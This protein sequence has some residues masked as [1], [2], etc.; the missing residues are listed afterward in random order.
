MKAPETFRPL[1]SSSS[2]CYLWSQK[3]LK[4]LMWCWQ[5]SR[6]PSRCW[7]SV[8]SRARS[9]QERT[10]RSWFGTWPTFWAS[11][12]GRTT[13]GPS[14]FGAWRDKKKKMIWHVGPA[15]LPLRNKS[16]ST[17]SKSVAAFS[18]VT[19]VN[20]TTFLL[21]PR[22]Q[23]VSGA[24][25][26]T[27]SGRGARK[28]KWPSVSC[29]ICQWHIYAA[30][31]LSVKFSVSFSESHWIALTPNLVPK[32]L[33]KGEGAPPWR[34]KKKDNSEME[35]KTSRTL[36][37]KRATR[38]PTDDR[39]E[40]VPAGGGPAHWLCSQRCPSPQMNTVYGWSPLCSFHGIFH[41]CG[42]TANETQYGEL[43]CTLVYR[44]FNIV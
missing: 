21:R 4:S 8:W 34:K 15:P 44:C 26:N 23:A 9:L 40:A 6:S 24:L 27:R 14:A 17:H 3:G 2:M 22:T 42:E 39:V 16:E 43:T 35:Q 33:S 28:R 5:L 1:N 19:G 18:S 11:A 29:L 31:V 41:S 38:T 20:E 7:W 12:E 30:V 32:F 36:S 25:A 10:R 37:S 13:T